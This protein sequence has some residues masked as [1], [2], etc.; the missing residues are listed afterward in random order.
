[1]FRT[2]VILGMHRSGTSCLTGSLQEAGLHL[3]DVNQKSRCNE[4]GTRENQAFMDLN[5]AVLSTADAS[6]DNPPT[7]QIKWSD[8]HKAWRDSV[9]KDNAQDPA[10]GF[11]DPRT[12]L[13]LDSWLE[14]LPDARLIATFRD[15]YAVARSLN[16][17][18]DMP[19]EQG[20][21]LW[22]AY[23]ERLLAACQTHDIAV[24]NYD[25]SPPLYRQGLAVLCAATGLSP[26]PDGFQFFETKL[27]RNQSAHPGELSPPLSTIHRRLRSAAR[28]TLRKLGGMGGMGPVI[29]N[30]NGGDASSAARLQPVSAQIRKKKTDTDGGE[31]AGIVNRTAALEKSARRGGASAEEHNEVGRLF[32]QEGDWPKADA[33][34]RRAQEAYCHLF[35]FRTIAK[36]RL[37]QGEPIAA[38]VRLG[39]LCKMLA[40]FG[41]QY[42]AEDLANLLRANSK[43]Q[44]EQE[45]ASHWPKGS[46]LPQRQF[47]PLP[48]RPE[49][50]RNTI[51]S[52]VIPAYQVKREDWLREALEGVLDQAPE[53]TEILVVNDAPDDQVAQQVAAS[54]GPRVR[55]LCNET[56]LGLVE[57]HNQCIAKAAGE[58]VHIL[59]QD[60]RIKPG[61]YE[62]LL[63]PLQRDPR[64]VAAMTHTG[65]IDEKGQLKS[66]EQ[67]LQPRGVLERW[68]IKLSLQ[69]RIQFPSIIVRRSAYQE[70]GGFT[71]SLKF[72]FDWDMWN[73]IAASGPIWFEPRA[74]AQFRVHEG[75]ATYRFGWLERV[76]DAMQ[77]VAHMA[78]LVPADQHRSI[79]EMA[80]YKFFE[81]YWRLLSEERSEEMNSDQQSL[82]DFLL[83]GW[84]SDEEAR[85]LLAKFTALRSALP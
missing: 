7:D 51:L 6:W 50:G 12:V 58:F 77:T 20:L 52:V 61:F 67:G 17:R 66:E 18:N 72:A 10:W 47:V 73:R 42:W 78:Q 55:Y 43:E 24:I 79:A 60:D 22:R 41:A 82:I 23:N 27:K 65:Y 3:G 63:A 40:R 84:A 32:A 11:K 71:P 59:H 30:R 81:R 38:R 74:L 64:L 34:Y 39:E 15:P 21:A 75:S 85:Q 4:K 35:G 37:S 8:E 57:N 26:P 76:Q 56:N 14:A 44:I 49:E 1:M 54:Y 68:P 48:D 83:S 36:P 45:S 25:W 80:M 13:M 31:K 16:K 69:V 70:V 53:Q 62:A 9:I 28:Q 5:D 19:M 33:A 29:A 2:I 46:V